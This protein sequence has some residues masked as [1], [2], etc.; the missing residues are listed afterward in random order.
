M[1]DNIGDDGHVVGYVVYVMQNGDKIYGRYDGT[2]QGAAEQPT[3]R[4]HVSGNTTLIGG[5]GKFHAIRGTLHNTTVAEPEKGFNESKNEGV[6]W[7]EK[8]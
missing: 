5:T 7:M 3:G 2:A 4:R 1:T 6:Y 8:E